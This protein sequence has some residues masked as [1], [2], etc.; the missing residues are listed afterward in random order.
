MY[1]GQLYYYSCI[2]ASIER[3]ST[4]SEIIFSPKNFSLVFQAGINESMLL[5]QWE[6][7][8]LLRH[9]EKR[10]LDFC[11]MFKPAMPKSVVVN[12]ILVH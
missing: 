10:L 1:N 2:I 3:D 11:N 7:K 8:V 5:N 4:I 6:E 9:Y 12:N